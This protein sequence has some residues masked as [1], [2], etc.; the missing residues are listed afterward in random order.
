MRSEGNLRSQIASS[1]RPD[2]L[3]VKRSQIATAYHVVR[4]NVRA[5]TSVG[6]RMDETSNGL[7]EPRILTI[8]D[9]RVGSMRT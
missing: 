8:R 7:L 6:G 2:V 4:S 5:L 1:S 3:G 9:R